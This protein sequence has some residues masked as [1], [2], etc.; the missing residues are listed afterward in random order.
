M[1]KRALENLSKDNP[2][3]DLSLLERAAKLTRQTPS[4]TVGA[5]YRLQRAFAK[6]HPFPPF[7]SFNYGAG[8]AAGDGAA[9]C[10]AARRAEKS[11]RSVSS[12]RPASSALATSALAT[13]TQPR[14]AL[15]ISDLATANS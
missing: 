7:R 11:R 4:P 13:R 3:V 15:L 12:S 8:R 5:D 6:R 14:R 1:D 2:G 10:S 9:V